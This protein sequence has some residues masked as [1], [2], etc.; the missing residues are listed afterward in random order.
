MWLEGFLLAGQPHNLLYLLLGTAY[1]LLVGALPGLG[2]LFG[3]ALML[4]FTFGM[5]PITGII[6][7][8]AI[9]AA[10]T[11]GDSITSILVNIPGGGVGSVPSCWDGYPLAKKRKCGYGS[12]DFPFRLPLRGYYR[13]AL[14]RSY[15]AVA[16]ILCHEDR[17]PGVLHAR[18]NGPVPPG[19]GGA[20][21]NH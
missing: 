3:V 4:P 10:T 9:H 15:I 5:T 18:L 16:G 19:S 2:P 1:G 20:R 7:L 12:R 13:L 17:Y 8:V 11:Y 14:P 6:F 21:R